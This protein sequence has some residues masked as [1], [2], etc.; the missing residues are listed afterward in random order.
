LMIPGGPE[1]EKPAEEVKKP[2]P[3]AAPR[4]QKKS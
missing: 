4:K 1:P 3:K 2:Q